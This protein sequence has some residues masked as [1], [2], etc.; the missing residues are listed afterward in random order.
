MVYL[1]ELAGAAIL[2]AGHIAGLYVASVA[3]IVLLAYM[4]SGAWL[5]IIGVSTRK[6]D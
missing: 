3:L 5:L 4:I 6:T 2:F 1:A